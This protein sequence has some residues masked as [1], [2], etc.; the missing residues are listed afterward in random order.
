[1]HTVLPGRGQRCHATTMGSS[2]QFACSQKR[3]QKKK[4]L[5]LSIAQT[6]YRYPEVMSEYS[7]K[8]LAAVEQV[9]CFN[10]I[11]VYDKELW[12]LALGLLNIFA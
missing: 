11:S 8:S 6:R 2:R 5:E 7:S 10:S 4:C 1:M 3:R 12:K 9:F